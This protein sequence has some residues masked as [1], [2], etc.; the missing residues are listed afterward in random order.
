VLSGPA[1]ELFSNCQ[2]FLAKSLR[3]LAQQSFLTPTFIDRSVLVSSGYATNFPQ[4]M[5]AAQSEL[6]S[7]RTKLFLAPASCLHLYAR[8][9]ASTLTEDGYSALLVG[10][11]A[12]FEAG[13]AA[14]PYRLAAFQML[15]LVFV[16]SQVYVEEQA[17]LVEK[18]ISESFRRLGLAGSFRPATDAFFL[19]SSEGARMMQKLKQL[20]LEWAS[21]LEEGGLALA[22]INRHEDYFGKAFAIK[23]SR[24]QSAH[25]ACAAF[26]L[27]R[28]TAAGLLTWGHD[29]PAWPPELSL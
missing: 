23:L 5:L 19:P 7:A 14:Y 10:P 1:A 16:G 8:L 24:Q 9:Q 12:R 29:R 3:P 4:Q 6:P 22:S 27:E 26:G 11:C 20:K 18:D 28:L 15:E 2:A 21:P 13:G 25:S 17:S